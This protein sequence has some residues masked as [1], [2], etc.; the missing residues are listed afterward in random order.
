MR[1]RWGRWHGYME[2]LEEAMRVAGQHLQEVEGILA[3]AYE[4]GTWKGAKRDSADLEIVRRALDIPFFRELLEAAHRLESLHDLETPGFVGRAWRPDEEGD[5]QTS[6]SRGV[7]RKDIVREIENL[8][9]PEG[10]VAPARI[11]AAERALQDRTRSLVIVLD[12]LVNTRNISAIVRSAEALGLQE[13]HIINRLGKPALERTLT[14]R[15]ER[16]VDIFWHNDGTSA[17]EA[18]RQRGYRI[19]AA[20]FGEDAVEVEAVPLLGPTAL[21]FGSEQR[22]VSAEVRESADGLFYLPNSGFTAYINVS[23]ATAISIY[24]LD[25]RMRESKLREPLSEAD[26]GA[27]R[28]AWYSMLARGDR[29]KEVEYLAWANRP[30][31]ANQGGR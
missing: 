23:V 12:H 6:V 3:S 13:I 8:E 18:L 24:A 4:R 29:Q 15:A 22:G 10:A 11:V 27:L 14:T 17:I 20:D 25:R 2:E 21:V 26:L 5:V 16:W 31:V 19:L 1:S 7:V 9:I 28:P 30:P